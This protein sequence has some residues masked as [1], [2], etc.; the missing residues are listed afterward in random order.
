MAA[1]MTNGAAAAERDHARPQHSASDTLPPSTSVLNDLVSPITSP[2]EGTERPPPGTGASVMR[3]AT[4]TSAL[5]EA[6]W[7]GAD[8][9]S[10]DLDSESSTSEEEEEEEEAEPRKKPIHRSY[11]RFNVGNKDYKTKGRVSK[12]DGRLNISVNETSNC[13]YLAK[14]LGADFLKNISGS[15]SEEKLAKKS[16]VEMLIED[17]PR[18]KLNIVV[19][20]MKECGHRVRIATHHVFKEFIEKDSS[21]EF[22]S[23]EGAPAELMAFMVKNPG[24]IP[25]MDTLKKGEVGRRRAQIAEMFNGFWRACINA[26]DYEKDISNLKM[27]GVNASFVADAI[28]ANPPSFAHVHC[29]ERLGIPLHLMFTFPYTPTQALPYPLANIKKS[30]VDPGYTNFMSYPLVEMMTWQGLGDLPVSTLWASGQLYRLK[31][32][33]T[34]LWSPGLVPK[35]KDCG[36][37]IDIAGFVFLDLAS[38]FEPPAQLAK[39]LEAGDPTSGVRALA[40]KGWGGLGDEGKTSDNIFM[41]EN[42]PHDWLFPKVQTVVHHGGAGT[43]AIGLKCGKPT[44]VVSFFGDQQFWGAMIGGAG[45]GAN[46]VPYTQLSADKLAE[47]IK[48]CLTGEARIAAEKITRGIE[49]EGD[50][51]RNAVASFHRSLVLRG[52]N[53]KR[54]CIL[55]DRV[56]VWVLKNTHLRLSVLAAE[57]PIEKRVSWKQLRLIRHNEWND[58]EGPGEPIIGVGYALRNT[59]TGVAS[60]ITRIPFKISKSTKKQAQ[61]EDQRRRLENIKPEHS[62]V[63][64][65]VKNPKTSPLR[66]KDINIPEEKRP[67]AGLEKADLGRRTSEGDQNNEVK[68]PQIASKDNDSV[69]LFEPEEPAAREIGERV[70]EGVGRSIEAV[71]LAP[72]DLSV[73]RITGMKSGLKAVGEEFV[74]GVY[75]GWTGLVMQPYHGARDNGAVGFVKSVGM[76]VTGFILK[77][78]AAI[79]GPFAYT[80]KGV[81]KEFTKHKQPTNFIR[82]ARIMQG[83]RD[84]KDLSPAEMEKAR[85]VI[86]H[87]WSVAQQFRVIVEGK[88]REGMRG[89]AQAR[90]ERRNWEESG[91]FENVRMAERTLGAR[92]KGESLGP[93]VDLQKKESA[94]AEDLKKDVIDNVQGYNIDA[95]HFEARSFLALF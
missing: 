19:M 61:H 89:K 29:A 35:P 33:Y 54:C 78:L 63:Q 79:L 40:S 72:L 81:H 43:T 6:I 13:G 84:L 34:Y 23:V 26:T 24:I 49:E 11:S 85:E 91:A 83:Q 68:S 4:N 18:S 27:L 31:V 10:S 44:M 5:N 62:E 92:K 1:I 38:T 46:P 53:S 16:S 8:D 32:P 48:Q 66:E 17:I 94:L 70:A 59:V 58:F 42:T 69:L 12:R 95:S 75:D 9:D 45:A 37:E 57:L 7:K 82:K 60:G 30:N 25:T 50:G 3:A 64:E 36:P 56:A 22:F 51:A 77:D 90:K 76:G 87:G 21:L 39:F 71:A 74:Y 88:R 67:A 41:L 2:V 65:H 15:T 52:P 80:A 55:E 86:S 28:I 73:A 93:V 14:A 47:G 20:N